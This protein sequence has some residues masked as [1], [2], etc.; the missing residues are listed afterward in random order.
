MRLFHG[1][2]NATSPIPQKG[3]AWNTFDGIFLT[4][5]LQAAKSHGSFI[6]TYDL[7]AATVLTHYQLN[8]ECYDIDAIRAVL[9]AE[10]S[11]G[12]DM[13]RVWEIVIED[14]G[15][16]IQYDEDVQLFRADDVSTAGWEAQRIRGRVA[17]AL[18]YSAVEMLDEHGT[19]YLLVAP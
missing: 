2:P 12:A 14:P 13:D 19:V 15:S 5:N 9:V 10:A 18:G 4:T 1:S 3:G 8:Y 11:R 16:E 7:P 6:H 17:A